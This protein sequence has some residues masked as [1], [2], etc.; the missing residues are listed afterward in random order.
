VIVKRQSRRNHGGRS[1]KSH[2]QGFH[3]DIT[4]KVENDQQECVMKLAQTHDV[5]AKTVHAASH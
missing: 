1:E 4:A 5:S 2:L 3:P